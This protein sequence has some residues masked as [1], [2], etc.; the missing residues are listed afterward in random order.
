MGS[1]PLL[2]YDEFVTRKVC[3]CV[4]AR[5]DGADDQVPR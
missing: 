4:V 5:G 2:S 3:E 1:F